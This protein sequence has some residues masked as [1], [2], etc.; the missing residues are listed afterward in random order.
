VGLKHEP[1]WEPPVA[2][3]SGIFI[4][5]LHDPAKPPAQCYDEDLELKELMPALNKAVAGLTA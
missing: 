2:I 1:G 3:H 5:P 4:M